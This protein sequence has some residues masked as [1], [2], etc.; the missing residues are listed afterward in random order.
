MFYKE[1]VGPAL[2]AYRAMVSELKRKAMTELGLPETEIVVRP[3]R[4]DDIGPTN[5]GATQV[6]TYGQTATT[7][8]T[9]IDGNTISDNRF[10]GI[11]GVW[12][13]GTVAS[14]HSPIAQIKIKRKGSVARYWYVEPIWNWENKTGY[15]DEPV[16]L[17]QNTTVTVENWGRTAGSIVEW[18]FIGAVAEK[19][20]LLINP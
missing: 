15:T 20:G 7:W 17:D 8:D 4:P 5:S 16:I 14:D 12:I 3:L 19:R 1:L 2:E 18:G 6:Y 11:N 13:A 10:V 9:V